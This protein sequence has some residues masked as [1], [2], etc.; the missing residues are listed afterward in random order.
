MLDVE[1]N[2]VGTK[3]IALPSLRHPVWATALICNNGLRINA[4]TATL[5]GFPC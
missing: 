2:T 4:T 1:P 3:Q 5:P